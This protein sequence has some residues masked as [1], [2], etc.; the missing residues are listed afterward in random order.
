MLSCNGTQDGGDCIVWS[1][2]DSTIWVDAED[3]IDDG[4]D[5]VIAEALDETK[6]KTIV[7]SSQVIPSFR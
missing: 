1:D 3:S 6:T 4:S 7:N 5:I 2:C